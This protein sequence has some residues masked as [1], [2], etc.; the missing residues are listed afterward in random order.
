M[1]CV[2]DELLLLSLELESLEE[3]EE[4]LLLVLLV[5]EFC[6]VVEELVVEELEEL[7]LGYCIIPLESN[8]SYRT[9]ARTSPAILD[10]IARANW[11]R[12]VLVCPESTRCS[13]VFIAA[14]TSA[15]TITV[16]PRARTISNRVNPVLR[17]Q[18]LFVMV[19]LPMSS[20]NR[21]KSCR[22]WLSSR[23]AIADS[24]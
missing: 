20:L 10:M 23:F 7:V 19:R 24:R 8:G 11:S 9:V 22:Y 3:L 12:C 21:L 2:V 5:L 6:A 1:V 16:R 13:V 4:E 17:R 15:M 14:P 18:R